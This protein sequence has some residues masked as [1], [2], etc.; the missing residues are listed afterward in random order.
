VPLPCPLEAL[1][2]R[3]PTL[4]QDR[5]GDP[6][7]EGG[8]WEERSSFRSLDL[9][10][11][12]RANSPSALTLRAPA[13]RLRLSRDDL[14]ALGEL[15]AALAVA[16]AVV[17]GPA[18]AAPG[19]GAAPGGKKDS[20]ASGTA[21][22]QTCALVEVALTVQLLDDA[23]AAAPPPASHAAAA[24]A[25]A[26]GGGGLELAL[27]LGTCRMAAYELSIA[28]LSLL[29]VTSL[30]GR[31]GV[32][33][34]TAHATGLTLS[35]RLAP[36]A[37]PGA[38][39]AL[40]GA[41]SAPAPPPLPW[42]AAASVVLLHCPR[43]AG[44]ADRAPAYLE[45][46]LLEGLP[47][48][49]AAAV[50]GGAPRARAPSPSFS[51]TP[52]EALHSVQVQGL[53]VSTDWG[54]LSLD[55]ATQLG[56]LAAAAAAP[57]KPPPHTSQPAQRARAEAP[58]A[59]LVVNMVDLALRHEPLPYPQSPPPPP[60]SSAASAPPASAAAS[61]GGAPAAAKEPPADGGRISPVALAVIVEALHFGLP[62]SR[63]HEP[64]AAAHEA[65]PANGRA[66][67]G[68]ELQQPQQ[69]PA[70]PL[71]PPLR[72]EA[73]C[74]TL[75]L[76]AAEARGSG[77]GAG[78]AVAVREQGLAGCGYHRVVQVGGLVGGLVS[79]RAWVS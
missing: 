49:A 72:C 22:A 36:P 2:L 28:E 70:K 29:R 11:R 23:P 32:A 10:E 21:Q 66:P 20:A 41:P 52:P 14:A 8:A 42:R 74:I 78:E 58:P 56:A 47:P 60:P 25:A 30:G 61:S 17:G 46:V 75:H 15:P 43:A 37:L 9:T 16:V 53:T 24:A 76:A 48:A 45:Y 64:P 73:H 34:S 57:P 44:A 55:W 77:W 26:A 51:K 68:P 19:K 27:G 12:C 65:S 13:A 18:A 3:C 71:A 33:L 5:W 7:G 50:P 31:Q 69:P 39:S 4:L 40:P 67:H 1:P 62:L 79:V 6:E 63:R 35:G 54:H 38:P 59:R